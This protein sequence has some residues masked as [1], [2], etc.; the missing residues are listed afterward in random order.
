MGFWLGGKFISHK[1]WPPWKIKVPQCA[2]HFLKKGYKILEQKLG[3]GFKYFLFSS[4]L[5]E[6]FQFD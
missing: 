6:D 5:G 2:Y 3:G 1:G 4:L